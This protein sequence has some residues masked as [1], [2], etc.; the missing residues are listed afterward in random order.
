MPDAVARIPDRGRCTGP[1]DAHSRTCAHAWH[2]CASTSKMD[3]YPGC[4][5]IA[6]IS[7]GH[8]VRA[9]TQRSYAAFRWRIRYGCSRFPSS[10]DLFVRSRL[11]FGGG[12]AFARSS[13]L[14]RQL[15]IRLRD[16]REFRIYNVPPFPVT[17]TYAL[18]VATGRYA[19][20]RISILFQF[21]GSRD[22]WVV[23]LEL[24]INLENDKLCMCMIWDFN[25]LTINIWILLKPMGKVTNA[26]LPF[27]RQ[28]S[29][30]STKKNGADTMWRQNKV[31]Y[32]KEQ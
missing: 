6:R 12:R 4:S 8:C 10:V 1:M 30:V 11:P 23:L 28:R 19:Y 18:G 15:A 21:D 31:L 29:G 24:N 9:M 20:S 26:K 7:S 3:R 5:E 14:S 13:F 32:I 25:I 27:L 22:L 16:W 2:T 17:S